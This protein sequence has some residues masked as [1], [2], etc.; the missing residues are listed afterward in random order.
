MTLMN[1]LYLPKSKKRRR[2]DYKVFDARK[3]PKYKVT[4]ATG[5]KNDVINVF[6]LNDNLVAKIKQVSVGFLPRFQLIN[7]DNYV[8]SF[9]LNLGPLKDVIYIS[10]LNW[11]VFGKIAEG[12]YKI[13]W[14]RKRLLSV[15]T[16][17]LPD[18]FFNQ[19]EVSLENQEP[20]MVAIAALLD[21]WTLIENKQKKLKLK[22]KLI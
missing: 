12:K 6:D 18:G 9:N 17:E 22:F 1:T 8:A 3:K 21:S 10:R 7:G 2:I 4:G 13:R 16:V 15:E 5:N 20:V 11:I 14:R 19:L